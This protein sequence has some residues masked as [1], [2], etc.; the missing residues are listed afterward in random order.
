MYH[1]PTR[2]C[3][4][5]ETRIKMVVNAINCQ[6]YRNVDVYYSPFS[7]GLREHALHLHQ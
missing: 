5:F 7:H 2:V 4:Y 3:R 6:V 1:S